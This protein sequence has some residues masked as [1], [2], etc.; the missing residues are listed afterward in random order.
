MAYIKSIFF[1]L[2]VV[3]VSA[4]F[5]PIPTMPPMIQEMFSTTQEADQDSSTPPSTD[6]PAERDMA[7]AAREM[8]GEFGRNQNQRQH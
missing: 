3:A 6:S 1:A 5:P 8:L 4:Q 7:Q 2:F